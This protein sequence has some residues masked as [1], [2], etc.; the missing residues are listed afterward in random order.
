MAND[1]TT[2]FVGATV[3]T[4]WRDQL[5]EKGGGNVSRAVCQAISAHYGWPYGIVDRTPGRLR[6]DVVSSLSGRA[7][8]RLLADVEGIV[9]GKAER[10]TMS[11]LMVLLTDPATG[12]TSEEK[13][14]RDGRKIC[15]KRRAIEKIIREASADV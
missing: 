3:P 11:P 6:C 12:E 5:A 8:K 2:E 13:R 7:V 10:S 9:L 4:G 15:V 1:R 14:S